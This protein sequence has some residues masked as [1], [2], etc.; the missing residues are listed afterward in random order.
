MSDLLRN[1]EK[2]S[3]Q[4]MTRIPRQLRLSCLQNLTAVTNQTEDTRTLVTANLTSS[5]PT[6]L[7]RLSGVKMISST[8]TF[9]NLARLSKNLLL[10]EWK[11]AIIRKFYFK[12]FSNLSKD[13]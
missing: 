13:V 9:S 3:H 2:P 8:M 7:P 11:N 6:K 1:P 10:K 12:Y 4:A 5:A